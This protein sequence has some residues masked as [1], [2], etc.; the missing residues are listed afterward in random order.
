LE[1][2]KQERQK[3]QENNDFQD[4]QRNACSHPALARQ[5]R[6]HPE[7]AKPKQKKIHSHEETANEKRF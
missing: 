1:S 5:G 4:E 6:K 2:E 7:D 3:T